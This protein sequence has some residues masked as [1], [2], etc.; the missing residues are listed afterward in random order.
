MAVT[1]RSQH[2]SLYDRKRRGKRAGTI[3]VAPFLHRPP[4]FIGSWSNYSLSSMCV[5]V[6][7]MDVSPPPCSLRGHVLYPWYVDA[8]ELVLVVIPLERR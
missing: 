7:D 5:G 1:E 6:P 8:R 2:K 4:C 3:S